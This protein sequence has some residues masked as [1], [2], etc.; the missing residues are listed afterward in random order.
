M[1]KV[2]LVA[3]LLVCDGVVVQTRRFKRTN[4]VGNAFTAVDFFNSWSVDEICILDISD[5]TEHTDEF[6][7]IVRELSKRCFV[8]LMVGGKI[9]K[10]QLGHEYIKAGADRLVLNSTIIENP[11]TIFELSDAYGKQCIVLSIDGLAN[12]KTKSGYEAVINN[13]K[14][15]TGLDVIEIAQK[16]VTLGA[17]ELMVNSIANDG[18]K[19]GYD[20]DLISKVS[21]SVKVPVIAMGGVSE[22]A[23]LVD[24]IQFGG[25]SAVAAGNIFH[26]VEHST[27]KAKEYMIAKGINC[28]RSEFYTLNTRRN[29]QYKI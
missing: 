25:A 23:H 17:S 10:P 29:I 20:L 24:G 1:N 26:Y 7:S 9:S 18:D 4:M 14:K 22:W 19:R 15:P 27:K 5:D 28:R 16:G 6:V 11:K 21:S 8:P 2:R 12:S 3:V 13:G